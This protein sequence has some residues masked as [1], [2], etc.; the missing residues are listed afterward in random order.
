MMLLWHIFKIKRKE[1][2]FLEKNLKLYED[3][4]VIDK[5]LTEH[6]IDYKFGKNNIYSSF[7]ELEYKINEHI[8][9]NY[10][11]LDSCK[12]FGVNAPIITTMVR[13][14]INPDENSIIL[15][16]I[17]NEYSSIIFSKELQNS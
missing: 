15:E 5:L 14:V 9:Q 4:P 2:K 10:I 13:Q 3:N 8:A 1:K 6:Y 17:L 7:L 16:N 12:I 11:Y